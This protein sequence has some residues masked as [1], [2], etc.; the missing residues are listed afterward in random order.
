MTP[1]S[2]FVTLES[3]APSTTPSPSPSFNPFRRRDKSKSKSNSLGILAFEVAITLSRLLSLFRSLSDE[4][5]QDLR[6]GTLR[7]QGIACL[8]S[9]DES[10]LLNLA[11]L[12]LLEELEYVAS[13]VSRL[14]RKC[15]DIDLARFDLVFSD[16]KKGYAGINRMEF[17]TRKIEKVVEKVEKLTSMTANLYVAMETLSEMEVYEKKL[18]SWKKASFMGGN[19]NPM[20]G[21][22]FELFESKIAFQ[23]KQVKRFMELSLWNVTYDKCTAMAA[24]IVCNIYIRIQS[25]FSPFA[26]SIS[27]QYDRQPKQPPLHF[28]PQKNILP[29]PE[30]SSVPVTHQNNAGGLNCM[31]LRLKTNKNVASGDRRRRRSSLPTVYNLASETTVGGA[32]LAVRYA[33]IVMLA[34]RVLDVTSRSPGRV[35]EEARGELYELLPEGLREKVAVRL[36]RTTRTSISDKGREEDEVD[37]WREGVGGVIRWLAEVARDTLRWQEERSVEKRGFDNDGGGARVKKGRKV[38][39]VQT[40]HYANLEKTE[41]AIVELLVGLSR[42][43]RIRT[44]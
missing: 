44:D 24:R 3:T 6:S 15:S 1:F 22:N 35:D 10:F 38:V 18:Q 33:N 21:T 29:L 17:G 30:L 27:C 23:R 28:H 25:F 39:L 40:L 20:E 34:E 14:S 8:I 31:A 32:G 11:G 4:E 5:L 26:S 43:C 9:T 42:M 7:S 41:T 2:S 36:R 37:A 12:E 19:N 13:S 16:L